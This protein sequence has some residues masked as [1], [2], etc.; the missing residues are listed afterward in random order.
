MRLVLEREYDE[1]SHK[2]VHSIVKDHYS[3]NIPIIL[4]EQQN[5]IEKT[6]ERKKN[7]TILEFNQNESKKLTS[8][9]HSY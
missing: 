9:I 5:I 4:F 7:T 8:A 3:Q 6:Y 2:N 1:P